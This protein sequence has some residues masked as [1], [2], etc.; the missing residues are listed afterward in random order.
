MSGSVSAGRCS[1]SMVWLACR[2][3]SS[4]PPTLA[5]I[6]DA[7]ATPLSDP[8]TAFHRCTATLSRSAR[9]SAS[10]CSSSFVCCHISII[11]R[12]SVLAWRSFAH[13][14]KYV[15]IVSI[16]SASGGAPRRWAS[17]DA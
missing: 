13:C 16:C 17:I 4:A 6:S 2:S 5:S 7:S 9:T 3:A 10:C 15:G 1:S 11:S 14:A 12:S 8:I